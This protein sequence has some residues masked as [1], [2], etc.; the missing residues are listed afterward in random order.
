VDLARQLINLLRPGTPIKFTG[1]RPGEKLHE[2]LVSVDEVGVAKVHPRIIH[3]APTAGL[4]LAALDGLDA[5]SRLEAHHLLA[6]E[7]LLAG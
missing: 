7:T 4:P 3:A 5:R 1:L 2:R 6:G